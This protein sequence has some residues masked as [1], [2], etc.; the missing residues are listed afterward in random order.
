MEAFLASNHGLAS[1]FTTL[2]FPS[3]FPVEMT[4]LA[5]SGLNRRGDELG[6]DARQVLWR[7]FEGGPPPNRR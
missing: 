6:P 2:K 7:I 5:E 4:A 3:Y 1:L